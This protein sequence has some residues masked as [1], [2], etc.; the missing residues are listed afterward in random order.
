[1]SNHDV[2]GKTLTQ[3]PHFAPKPYRAYRNFADTTW[4]EGVLSK[5][6]KE[7]IAV[8]VAHSTKCHY[9]IQLHTKKAKLA[10]ARLEELTETV[11]VTAAVEAESSLAHAARMQHVRDELDGTFA[12]LHQTNP[13]HHEAAAAFLEEVI[14]EGVL[15]AKLKCLIAVAIAH[16]TNASSPDHFDAY[17][18]AAI[19]QGATNAEVGEA[20]FIAA[21]MKA[22]ATVTHLAEMIQ[23]YEG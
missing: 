20:I 9:C 11:M 15:S 14:Q 17:R 22:G 6:D 5:K 4:Q 7:I 23:A 16:T 19:K 12:Y 10:K 8:A 2:I 21:T 3:V 1:M 18:Q 13:S